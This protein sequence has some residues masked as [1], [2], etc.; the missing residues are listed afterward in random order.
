MPLTLTPDE[1]W[2]PLPAAQ[3]DAAAARHLLQRA[4]WAARP[5][6]ISRA[7]ADGLPA[8]LARLFPAQ[9]TPLPDPPDVTDIRAE[10]PQ[11]RTRIRGASG[12]ERRTLQQELRERERHAIR[13]LSSAWLTRAAQ[14]PHAATE[15]WTLFLSD[16]YVVASA[17]VRDAALL[18]DHFNLLRAHAFASAPRLTKAVS[19]SPAMIVYLD[20][21]ENRPEAPN[22]NF[23]RELFELFVLGE[24]H[25]SE[26]D[27]K[28]AARAFTGYRRRADRFAFAR[29][30]HDTRSVTLFGHTVP[31][32]GDAVIDLAY[33]QPAAHAFLPGELARF[34]LSAEPLP[35]A[36]L[37]ALG[38]AWRAHDFDLRWLAHTFFGSRLFFDP[39]YRGNLIK[40]PVQ[41][42]LG[43]L[44]D[45][46]LDPAP[47][48]RLS[49][50]PLRQ[51]GQM[52]FNPPNVR[53]WV[54]G[55]N[56][57]NSATLAARRQLVQ[58]L[59]S[60]FDESVLNADEQRALARARETG[61]RDFTLPAGHLSAWAALPP[62]ETAATLVHEF[63]PAVSTRAFVPLFTRFLEP[64]SSPRRVRDAVAALLQSPHYQLC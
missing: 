64:S 34:Y 58:R 37:D 63:L 61:A 23:A 49:L 56:W 32:D 39:A 26:N 27:I 5:N 25:Y 46:D 15:K 19:R 8:T 24:G 51:M 22:E 7:V 4:G 10:A 50:E 17:K 55:R 38:R 21:Q 48:P 35:S 16:V 36:Q 13:S 60:P 14:P 30:Q 52:L 12:D 43:L 44:Q 59:V 1:A 28:A 6:E 3:W 42:Y 20:L 40:S 54:G 62:A 29:R 53:G 33:R 18:A 45:L 31:A 47:L 57:I 9:C 41:F 2:Q 11:Y